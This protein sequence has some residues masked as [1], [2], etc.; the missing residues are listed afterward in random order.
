[1]TITKNEE[2]TIYEL[3]LALSFLLA[4]LAVV[5]GERCKR[6]KREVTT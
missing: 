5:N 3:F 1:M 2:V 4:V 6:V